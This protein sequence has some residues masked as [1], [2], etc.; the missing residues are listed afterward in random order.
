MPKRK[1]G[2]VKLP[3]LRKRLAHLP[4]EKIEEAEDRYLDLIRQLVE[5]SIRLQREEHEAAEGSEE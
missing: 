1:F 5:I 3:S 2:P 4:E